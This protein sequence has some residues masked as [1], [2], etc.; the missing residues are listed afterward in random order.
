MKCDVME[1]QNYCDVKALHSL[2]ENWSRGTGLSAIVIDAEGEFASPAY[3]SSSFCDLVKTSE[4]GLCRCQSSWKDKIYGIHKCH[5]GFYDLAIP[6]T[7]P[8]GTT[9]G[10][11]LAGQ[12]MSEEQ[13]IE[14]IVKSVSDLGIPEEE[15]RSVLEKIPRKSKAEMEGSYNLLKQMIDFFLEKSYSEYQEREARKF[16]VT[17]LTAA[18]K[19][20]YRISMYFNVT[21]NEYHLI[22]I[23]TGVD[24]IV[25]QKGTIDDI[26]TIG[27]NSIPNKDQAQQYYDLFNRNALVDAYNSG[28]K[29]ISLQHEQIIFK[30]ECH[31]MEGRLVFV[32]SNNGEINAVCLSRVIDDEIKN[33]LIL[34]DALENSKHQQTLLQE[35]LDNYKQADYDR[36]RDFLTGLR[37]RQDMFDL[38]NDTLSGKR[39]QIKSMFM[40]DID[41][42][43]NLNDRF[44]HTYG[45]ECLQ[46][47]GKALIEYGEKNNMYFYRYG[48]EEMLGIRFDNIKKDKDIAEELVGLVYGLNLKR[49]DSEFGVVTVSLGYTSDNS[50]Y[51]KM[52]DKADNAMYLAKRNGK[53]QAVCY[54]KKLFSI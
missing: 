16:D 40:M 18:L 20:V 44:G 31:W 9:I 12:M 6:L 27:V 2:L 52:I 47:I 4:V 48:G 1:L 22:D 25:P 39:T 7:L 32:D 46:K 49:D 42:F 53:N 19:T 21:K 45:D 3:G 24:Q 26:V 14:E 50:R 37:N 13:D 33:K 15:I 43:K 8:D 17:M 11:I 10:K 35:A 41:N 51:E 28:K 30:G 38:F 5:A 23:K 54:D 29:E 34:N 36:R